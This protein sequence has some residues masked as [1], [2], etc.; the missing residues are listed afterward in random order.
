L[1]TPPTHNGANRLGTNYTNNIT[2]A[3]GGT[4]TV[5]GSN[6]SGRPEG[7]SAE[8]VV[9]LGDLSVS[10][11]AAPASVAA[12]QTLLF[13][14]TPRNNGRAIAD[15]NFSTQ[16]ATTITNAVP[17]TAL[18]LGS[19]V[20]MTDTLPSGITLLSAP[21]GAGWTC[22]LGTNTATCSLN[23]LTLPIAAASNFNAITV[24]ARVTSAGC[25]GPQINSASVGDF[26]SPY[27][28]AQP[29]NN[30]GTASV[31][32]N[33]NANLSITKTNTVTSLTAGGTTSYLISATNAGPASADGAVLRDIPS[34]GL[35]CTVSNCAASGGSPVATCPAP[36]NWPNLLT[37]GGV[38]APSFPSGGNIQ[39]TVNCNVTATGVP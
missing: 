34:A 32:L 6:Y 37:A 36:A 7:P 26:A 27:T 31:S 16:Q 8:D 2:H 11:I 22:S 19:T 30:T 18:L 9:L 12:G 25:P 39:F 4:T 17:A 20:R 24:A 38:A 28:D 23:T 10:K 21:T 15:I 14:I 35:S 29:S 1:I 5:S 3:S 33:C 13:T